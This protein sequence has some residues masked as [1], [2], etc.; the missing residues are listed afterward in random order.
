[1]RKKIVTALSLLMAGTMV[2]SMTACGG[3][4]GNG[5]TE[6]DKNKTQ[7]YVF[8]F[9]GG[10]GTDWLYEAAARFEK[11][12][13]NESYEDGKTGVEIKIKKQKSSVSAADNFDKMTQEIFFT[14]GTDYFNLVNSNKALDITTAVKATLTQYGE[15]RSVYDKFSEEQKSYYT[16]DNKI[17]AIPHYMA[18]F[19]IAYNRDVFDEGYWIL[20]DGYNA[21]TIETE[22]ATGKTDDSE[23]SITFGKANADGSNLSPGP[24]G[25]LTTT[26]DNGFPATYAEYYLLCN[27]LSENSIRAVH[28][29]GAQYA[30]YGVYMLDALSATNEGA[31][32]WSLNYD[33]SSETLAT[34]LIA[35]ANGDNLPDFDANGKPIIGDSVQITS[36]NGY[37]LS[38]QVGK[39][40]AIDFMKNIYDHTRWYEQT[41][42]KLYSS[43]HTH[44]DAQRDFLRAGSSQSPVKIAMLMDGC[45]WESEGSDVFND[46]AE[47]YGDKYKRENRNFGIMPLPF[48]T[49]QMIG[50][51]NPTM[52]DLYQAIGFIKSSI[53]EWKIPLATEFLIFCSTDA[54][55]S[56]YTAKTS[57]FKSLNYEVSNEAYAK[58]SPY[59]KSVIEYAKHADVVYTANYDEF[60][61]KNIGMFTY[62]TLFKGINTGGGTVQSFLN[63][64]PKN[65]AGVTA[66][67]YI[68]YMM[69]YFRD[70]WPA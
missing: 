10:Y 6:I 22:Y 49:A 65:T 15:T 57:T 40:Y 61:L 55:M 19:G 64:Y 25:D 29:S 12:K 3:T 43:T 47:T 28:W 1:M 70:N 34:N 41:N 23:N 16:V 45:W 5:G 51:V 13:E 4:T 26:Y 9:D 11:L 2:T 8:N 20:N 17:Y 27:K 33:Y 38:Q 58:A 7:L 36:E 56:E 14:E 32:Q 21:G 39:Y 53:A 63:F 30:N 46:L 69:R 44:T 52:V 48:A 18:T 67:D 24:D 68:G 66:K 31:A 54:E 42:G 62:N 35:D 50:S 59:G 37:L 60:Y